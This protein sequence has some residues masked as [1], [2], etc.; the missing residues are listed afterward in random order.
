MHHNSYTVITLRSLENQIKNGKLKNE[1]NSGVCKFQILFYF[2]AYFA[3]RQISSKSKYE[4]ENENTPRDVNLYEIPA[5][6]WWN[7]NFPYC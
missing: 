7:K 2:F 1:L 4:N 6:T 5:T 3:F